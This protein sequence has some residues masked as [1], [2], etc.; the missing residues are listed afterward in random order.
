[1]YS[2]SIFLYCLY[3]LVSVTYSFFL[4]LVIFKILY[5]PIFFFFPFYYLW[6]LSHLV[7][8]VLFGNVLCGIVAF[9]HFCL[10][11]IYLYMIK[12]VFLS[13]RVLSYLLPRDELDFF[14]LLQSLH[15]NIS[16]Q[17]LSGY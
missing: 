1:M 9:Q 10:G 14:Q 16:D 5:S 4:S 12:I 11:V 3:S 15:R 13:N 7:L 8:S 17:T 2:R 6:I